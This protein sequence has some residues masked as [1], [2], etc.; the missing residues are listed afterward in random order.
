LVLKKYILEIERYILLLDKLWW[1]LQ[2]SKT[3]ISQR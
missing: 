2:R 1:V 3:N